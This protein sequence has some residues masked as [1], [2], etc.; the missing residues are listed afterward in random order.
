VEQPALGPRLSSSEEGS[1]ECESA[2]PTPR[3]GSRFCLYSI[4]VL[5]PLPDTEMHLRAS[6]PP[7]APPLS[8]VVNPL[9]PQ[10]VVSQQT[11]SPCHWWPRPPSR[12]IDATLSVGDPVSI[13]ARNPPSPSTRM[14]PNRRMPRRQA[15]HRH[16]D[17][18]TTF[19]SFGGPA[20][21]LPKVLRV[22][23]SRCNRAN[24]TS[25]RAP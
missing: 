5:S 19:D 17:L 12:S 11:M 8:Y 9:L 24:L 13:V 3:D 15:N 7:A 20:R 1:K 4:R 21:Q 10:S 22:A 2:R 18:D 14:G 6:L 23:G 25:P 16:A